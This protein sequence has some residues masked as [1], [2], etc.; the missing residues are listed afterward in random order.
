MTDESIATVREVIDLLSKTEPLTEGEIGRLYSAY[1]DQERIDFFASE[2]VQKKQLA[3]IEKRQKE[4]QTSRLHRLW[5]DSLSR[6]SQ[7]D[8]ELHAQ[9]TIELFKKFTKTGDIPPPASPWRI[10]VLLRKRN[11]V[12]L[13]RRFLEAWTRHFGNTIGTKYEALKQRYDK[14]NG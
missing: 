11:E 10:A 13:E 4:H 14:L 5:C 7:N 2:H 1:Q 6:D 9:L 12:D 3:D 8:L